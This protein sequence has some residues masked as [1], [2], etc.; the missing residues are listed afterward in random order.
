MLCIGQ[1]NPIQLNGSIEDMK[2][3]VIC[4]LS[5]QRRNGLYGTQH[6]F[7]CNGHEET[8]RGKLNLIFTVQ[9]RCFMGATLL[10]SWRRVNI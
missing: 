5:I 1:C 4:E 10:L 7:N 9:E 6:V 8:V 2:Q 3:G